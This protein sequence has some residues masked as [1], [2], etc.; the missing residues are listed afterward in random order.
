MILLA[1]VTVLLTPWKGASLPAAPSGAEY[2][3][4]YAMHVRGA[5]HQHVVLDADNVA[6]GWIAAFCTSR[7]CSP[8]HKGL[9]LD[10][11]GAALLEFSL[12]RTD[13]KASRHTHVVVRADSRVVARL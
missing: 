12:V 13:P 9:D 3:V 8:F 4:S 5:A 7:L 10:S 11:H 2:S 1:L 6:P